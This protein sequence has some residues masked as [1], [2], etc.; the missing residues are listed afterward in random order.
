MV[1]LYAYFAEN[2]CN[3]DIWVPSGHGILTSDNYPFNYVDPR[4][5][6]TSKN[7]VLRL[8]PPKSDYK[9]ICFVFQRFDL[10]NSTDCANDSLQF[11]FASLGVDGNVLSYCG[12]GHEARLQQGEKFSNVFEPDFCCKSSQ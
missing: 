2:N 5:P 3:Q 8:H 7:C 12:K 6:D 10:E 4:P 11:P 1:T 9:Q